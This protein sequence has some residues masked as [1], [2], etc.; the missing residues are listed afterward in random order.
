MS[1]PD[2]QCTA[3]Q[4]AAKDLIKKGY[5]GILDKPFRPHVVARTRVV[6][7]QYAVAM[8]YI[9]MM[10]DWGDSIRSARPNSIEA[11]NEALL[12]YVVA[13]N[14]LSRTPLE[15]PP[16]G[17]PRA[18]T[19]AELKKDLDVMGNALVDLEAEFPFNFGV[20]RTNAGPGS[21]EGSPL[22]GIGRTLYFC[23]PRNDKLLELYRTA[24][25]RLFK[26]RHCMDLA[27][28]VRKVPLF[29][30]PIDPGMLVKAAAAGIDVDSIVAGMNEPIGPVR[31]EIMIQKA[32]ELASEVR[33]MGNA[34]LAAIEKGDAERLT[35]LRQANELEIQ[36]LT[37]DIRYLQWKQLS[38]PRKRSCAPERLPSSGIART[39]GCSALLLME[40]CHPTRSRSTADPS[41]RRA[42]MRPTPP[43][44]GSTTGPSRLRRCHS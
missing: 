9:Q 17:G 31:A 30:P 3:Q 39:S 25:D 5:A 7:Y 41:V 8:A 36:R 1:Q 43:S 20:P 26:V 35:R 21:E 14:M 15:V 16:V 44:S 34:L 10:L 6:A 32:L 40:A 11:D 12:R 29:D 2:T 27:G 38:R 28:V 42:L 24:A 18:K 19:Y 13:T 37:Q 23:V 22:L 33:A 4:L